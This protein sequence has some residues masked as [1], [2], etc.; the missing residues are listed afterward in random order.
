M[1]EAAMDSRM[2]GADFG[3]KKGGGGGCDRFTIEIRNWW[4]LTK[5]R[6]P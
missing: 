3:S 5:K 2:A 6:M 1:L 4:S